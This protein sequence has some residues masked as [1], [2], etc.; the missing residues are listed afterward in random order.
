[1]EKNT[2]VHEARLGRVRAAVWKNESAK[3]SWYSVTI[4]KLYKD[5]DGKWQDG[6][7]FSREDLP[8]LIKVADEAYTWAY[9][10]PIGVEVE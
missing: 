9:Q 5:E 6:H 2:P 3:G 4:A 7:N 10:H 8:L 1:M